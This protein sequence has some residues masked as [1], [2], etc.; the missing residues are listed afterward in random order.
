M[1]TVRNI[2]DRKGRAVVSI[3]A[4]ASVLDALALMA[5]HNIGA[6]LIFEGDSFKGIFTERDYA[7][8]MAVKGTMSHEIPVS[9]LYTPNVVSV[10]PQTS[11]DECMHLMTGHRFRHLPVMEN[12]GLCGMISIGDVVKAVIGEREETIEQ[13]QNYITGKR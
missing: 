5:K 2:L 13:L 12:G 8:R 9:Q 6:L 7:R 1:T 11:I 3:S 10:T 4:S